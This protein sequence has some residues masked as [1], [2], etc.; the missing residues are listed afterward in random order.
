MELYDIINKIYA[1]PDESLK[2]L[3]ECL[4]MIKRPKGY[5]VLEAEKTDTNIY[6]IGEGIARAYIPNR[7]QGNHILDRKRGS[8]PFFTEKLCQ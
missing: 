8:K 4:T 3:A 6:L 5:H 7:W 2:R 1:M